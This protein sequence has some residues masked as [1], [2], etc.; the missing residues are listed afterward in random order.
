MKK[1][2]IITHFYNHPEQVEAQVASWKKIDRSLLPQIEFVLI[3]D[4]SDVLP[5]I[6][7][8]DLD[9]KVYRIDSDIA[10]NQS[11]AR[12]LGFFA[13]T[14][15]WCLVFDIDQKLEVASLP[16]L[17]GNLEQLDRAA[18]YYLKA[19]G[20]F[21]RNVN[22]AFEHHVN[23][24]LVSLNEF[25]NRAMYDE[26]FAGH[27]GYEDLLVPYVWERHGGRRVLLSD[28]VFFSE[29]S[30]VRTENLSRDLEVNKALLAR[31][32][33]EGAR[34]PQNFL[35]FTWRSVAC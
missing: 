30:S 29:D 6:V 35:R 13:A 11:G 32:L 15:D 33:A 19:N 1:L 18:M 10:W 4:C 34:R 2:S 27:Y 3:D 12:N 7:P 22:Q 21:D 5:N 14:G 23:T 20:V 24:F 28:P 8:D 9:L 25:K 17:L 16:A 26:D 31:K